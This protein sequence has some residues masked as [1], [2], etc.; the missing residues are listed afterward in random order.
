MH[1]KFLRPVQQAPAE[2]GRGGG[3]M[4]QTFAWIVGR[5]NTRKERRENSYYCLGKKRATTAISDHTY[6]YA[7]ANMH[8][9]YKLR[10]ANE[11]GSLNLKRDEKRRNVTKHT[12][13]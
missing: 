9:T 13:L 1:P 4:K 7:H 3:K 2:K 11:S 8:N 12:R 6:M 10:G 5:L